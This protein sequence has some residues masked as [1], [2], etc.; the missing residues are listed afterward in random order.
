MDGEK[1]GCVCASQQRRESVLWQVEMWMQGGTKL[2][3]S[4]RKLGGPSP[5]TGN[6]RRYLCGSGEPE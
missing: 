2:D 3:D 1:M 6:R 5:S 4:V